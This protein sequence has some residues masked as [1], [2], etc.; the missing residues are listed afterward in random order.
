MKAA[1]LARLN[2]ARRQ[3]VAV[4]RAVDVETGDE[5]L[6]DPNSDFE[7]ARCGGRSSVARRPQH[8]S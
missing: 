5:I 8:A 1:T 6:I 3:G 2:A 4:V 7:H